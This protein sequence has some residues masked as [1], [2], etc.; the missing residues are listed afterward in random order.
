MQRDMWEHAISNL[1]QLSNDTESKQVNFLPTPNTLSFFVGG[2]DQ[3]QAS[4]KPFRWQKEGGG[5]GKSTVCY[6]PANKPNSPYI[7]LKLQSAKGDVFI[8]NC[9]ILYSTIRLIKRQQLR[10]TFNVVQAIWI[11]MKQ[12]RKSNFILSWPDHQWF[13][14]S[15]E[16]YWSNTWRGRGGGITFVQAL[17]DPF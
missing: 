7:S 15:R 2:I 13:T 1:P 11:E 10:K 8:S 4:S 9:L 3:E 14:E 5:G 17:L 12:R 6:G 16:K